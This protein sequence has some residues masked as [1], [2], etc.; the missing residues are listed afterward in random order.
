M[1]DALAV[2][3]A[4]GLRD[5]MDCIDPGSRRKS[6][7]LARVRAAPPGPKGLDALCRLGFHLCDGPHCVVRRRSWI[8]TRKKHDPR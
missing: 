3:V 4:T 2:P 6:F 8:A 1:C 7:H 5:K